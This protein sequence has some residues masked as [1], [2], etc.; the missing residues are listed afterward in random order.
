MFFTNS[1]LYLLANVK[2]IF[3]ATRVQRNEFIGRNKGIIW[4]N[5][6]RYMAEMNRRDW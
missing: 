4:G 2:L 1:Y 6:R 5:M 3:C